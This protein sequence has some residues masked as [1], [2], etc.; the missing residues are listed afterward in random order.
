MPAAEELGGVGGGARRR[1]GGLAV[2]LAAGSAAGGAGRQQG[3]RGGE[4]GPRS[5]L[6]GE[7][8][9]R[10]RQDGV[11]KGVP[12][13]SA[14]SAAGL[15]GHVEAFESESGLVAGDVIRNKANLLLL[16]FYEL[17]FNRRILDAVESLLGPGPSPQQARAC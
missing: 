17:S 8:L 7:Q 1:L 3:P 9:A 12:V 5:L 13:L 6:T 11:L 4:G 10:Y 15:L 14:E 16:P 2:Q